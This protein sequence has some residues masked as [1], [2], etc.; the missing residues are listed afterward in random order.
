[1]FDNKTKDKAKRIRQTN[2]LL[3]VIDDMLLKNGGSPYANELFK[4]AQVRLAY[5]SC[6][7][8]YIFWRA[9][10]ELDV[11]LRLCGV[12]VASPSENADIYS[13]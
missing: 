13:C 7:F 2:D 10:C 12:D 3:R 6:I 4:E 9:S 1:L 5:I 11:S 8:I